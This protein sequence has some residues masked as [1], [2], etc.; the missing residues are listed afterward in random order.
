MT[1]EGGRKLERMFAEKQRYI[2]LQ[3][4]EMK[5]KKMKEEESCALKCSEEEKAAGR[6]E[7]ERC[8]ERGEE[9]DKPLLA[10]TYLQN[11]H[12]SLQ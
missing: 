4:E 12:S 5:G 8:E 9:S 2:D 10:H 7:P 1:C 11:F 6:C 3:G